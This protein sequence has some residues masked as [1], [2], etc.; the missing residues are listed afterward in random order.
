MQMALNILTGTTTPDPKDGH[1]HQYLV[2]ISEKGVISGGIT[3]AHNGHFHQITQLTRT[4]LEIEEKVD[5]GPE[6]GSYHEIVLSESDFFKHLYENIAKE[7]EASEE[8]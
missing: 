5:P 2:R 8:D 4:N 3:S 6:S 7:I 1:T